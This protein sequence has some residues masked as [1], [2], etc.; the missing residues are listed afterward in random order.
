VVAL[1]PAFRP[2]EPIDAVIFDA[3]GVLLLP[4]A[5]FGQAALQALK[6]ES[7]LEDWP[8]AYY[9]ANLLLDSLEVADWGGMRRTIASAVGVPDEQLDAAVPL[10]EQLI[11]AAPWVPV[12]G[13]VDLLWRLAGAGYQLAVVSNAFGTIQRQLE[14]LKVCS[15][16]GEGLPRVGTVIDSHVVGV[17]KPDA[18]IFHLALAALEVDASR[19]I[20]VGD[21]V[22]FDVLGAEAAGLHPVHFDPFGLCSGAHSHVSALAE[23]G[24][25]LAPS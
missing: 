23:V 25:W 12:D 4:D 14:E 1:P 3:G 6:H 13:A 22:K 10:I 18:R 15:V 9:E 16:T 11:A 2:P 8:R 7:R 17:A 19:S 5:R 21:T 20:Y 24:D